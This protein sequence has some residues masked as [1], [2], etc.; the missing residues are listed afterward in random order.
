MKRART[1]KRPA[2]GAAILVVP[3]STPRNPFV[4]HARRRK[5]GA[6]DG[7]A[8]TRRREEKRELKKLLEE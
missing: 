7:G 5:A 6:H 3:A 1:A 8:R 4:A 2:Q